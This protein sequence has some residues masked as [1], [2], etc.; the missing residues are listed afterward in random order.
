[1]FGCRHAG[2]SLA[3]AA[4]MAFLVGAPTPVAAASASAIDRDAS[5]A[6]G[7]LYQE[8]PAAKGLAKRAKAIL[9]FP[10]VVKGGLLVGGQFGEGAL[11]KG[12]KT[13]GA[14]TTPPRSPMASRRVLRVSAM[15]CS[16]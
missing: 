4:A 5:A 15:P 3:F 11:R 6:L 16:S 14:T 2:T 13:M 12:G 8:V 10:S 7:K 1:M 9:V